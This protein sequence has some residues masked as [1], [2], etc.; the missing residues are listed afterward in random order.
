MKRLTL[1]KPNLKLA[2][3]SHKNSQ[4]RVIGCNLQR[5]NRHV[6]SNGSLEIVNKIT[7]EVP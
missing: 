6:Q 1:N 4:S 7:Y 3:V 2:C 5:E